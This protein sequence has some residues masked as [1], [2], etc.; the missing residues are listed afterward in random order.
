[1]SEVY[2]Y[3]WVVCAMYDIYIYICP[4]VSKAKGKNIE[5]TNISK[6]MYL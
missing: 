3:A 4:F 1:M 2:K 5:K 6:Y